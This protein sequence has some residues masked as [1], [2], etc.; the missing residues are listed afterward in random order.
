VSIWPPLTSSVAPRSY[1][2]HPCCSAFLHLPPALGSLPSLPECLPWLCFLPGIM[3]GIWHFMKWWMR[4]PWGLFTISSRASE[5][6]SSDTFWYE[7]AHRTMVKNHLVPLVSVGGC[8]EVP[9]RENQAFSLRKGQT[10]FS[11]KG[12]WRGCRAERIQAG[13]GRPQQQA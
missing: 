5:N 13:Y 10:I 3:N 9:V 7:W 2:E 6:D 11:T 8:T 4:K 1:T 12:K